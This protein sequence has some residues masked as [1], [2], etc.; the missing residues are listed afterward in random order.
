MAK[1]RQERLEAISRALVI[2]SVQIK[3]ENLVGMNSLNSIA[4]DIIRPTLAQLFDCPDLVSANIEAAN[5]DSVDLFSSLKRLGFQV[6]TNTAAEKITGTL[7]RLD[8]SDWRSKIDLIRFIVLSPDANKRQQATSNGWIAAAPAGLQFEVIDGIPGLLSIIKTA[9]EDAIAAI[10]DSLG[11]SII[12]WEFRDPAIAARSVTSRQLDYEQKTGKYIPEL[13]VETRGAKDLARCLADPTPFL[14]WL[15][16]RVQRC[17]PLR[18]FAAT[19]TEFG[20]EGFEL[21]DWNQF[22][23]SSDGN[24]TYEKA[25]ALLAALLKI[26][27]NA[28]LLRSKSNGLAEK[29]PADMR[30]KFDE[31]EHQIRNG[32]YSIEHRLN[33]LIDLA[34]C[35]VA[36]VL[37]LVSPAGQGK[38]M[39]ICDFVDKCLIP[40]GVTTIFLTGHYLSQHRTQPLADV[41]AS[42][43]FPGTSLSFEEMMNLLNSHAGATGKPALIVIDALNEHASTLDFSGQLHRLVSDCL[44]YQNLRF[45]FTCRTEFYKVRF[46]QLETAPLSTVLKTAEHINTSM[47]DVDRW[48]M[49]RRHFWFFGIDRRLVASEV[50]KQLQADRILLRIFCEAYGTDEGTLHFIPS[51]YRVEVFDAYLKKR[52]RSAAELMAKRTDCD[53]HNAESRILQTLGAIAQQMLASATFSELPLNVIKDHEP[54][55]LEYLMGEEVILRRDLTVSPGL[56]SK[57]HESVSFT[58]DEFRDYVLSSFLVQQVFPA[59]PSAFAA[60]LA[61]ANKDAKPMAEGVIRFLFHMC[62]APGQ[63]KL[64]V[65]CRDLNIFS[66]IFLPEIFNCPPELISDEDVESVREVLAYAPSK[67]SR[68]FDPADYRRSHQAH[69]AAKILIRRFDPEHYPK[70]NLDLL[71]DSIASSDPPSMGLISSCFGGYENFHLQSVCQQ[72]SKLIMERTENDEG[73][74]SVPPLLRLLIT[75]L[76]LDSDFRL[77]SPAYEALESVFSARPSLA[78]PYLVAGLNGTLTPSLPYLWR[79]AANSHRAGAHLGELRELATSHS[80]VPDSCGREAKRFLDRLDGEGVQ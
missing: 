51:L 12:G 59:D 22:R 29:V 48:T 63:D 45:L 80:Q 72:I 47:R 8:G 28:A 30:A 26:R 6:T 16:D 42:L 60:H 21:P 70:L 35:L 14:G 39:F 52:V 4:E 43:L 38:T 44:P 57:V 3:N 75:I 64:A 24:D 2:L 74:T 9:D 69:Q 66:D 1:S 33:D 77:N 18:S 36:R 76:P 53:V 31:V 40:R 46:G 41:L 20:L 67:T 61:G 34:Q 62:R 11:K 73:D 7:K 56:F 23:P 5:T 55:A 37:V 50:L 65:A 71:L 58:F 13:F 49:L 68:E 78:L 32:V 79:L 19:F 25:S 10:Y 54:A 15:C 27:S 17:S